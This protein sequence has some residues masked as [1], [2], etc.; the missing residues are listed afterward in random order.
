MAATAGTPHRTLI[1]RLPRRAAMV[2][3]AEADHIPAPA[4]V[5]IL[6]EAAEVDRIRAVEA[7]VHTRIAKSISIIDNGE[8]RFHERGAGLK[9][10][11]AAPC[12]I[13]V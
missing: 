13:R 3:V 2:V 6:A 10:L 11:V 9:H 4:E 12:L 1:V 7:V 5:H 8:A